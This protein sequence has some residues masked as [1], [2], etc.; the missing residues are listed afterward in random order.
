MARST[1]S[2]RSASGTRQAP[3][4]N[5]VIN[6]G[7]LFEDFES[8]TGWSTPTNGTRDIDTTYVKTGSGSLKFGVNA[9]TANEYI[10]KTISADMSDARNISFWMYIPS[11]HFASSWIIMYF[12]SVSNFSKYFS[13]SLTSKLHEGWNKIVIA[14]SEWLNSGGESWSNTMIR[15]RWRVYADGTNEQLIYFDSIYKQVYS[16]PKVLITFDDGWESQYTKAYAYMQPLGLKGTIYTIGSKIGTAGY[17]TTANLDTLYAAGWDIA[18]HGSV[19]L[20]TLNTQ[21][22]QEAEISSEEAY[23][24]KYQRSKKHY[25]YPGGAYNENARAALSSLEYLTARTIIDRQQANNL[26]EKYLLTRYGIYHTT[27]VATAIGYIDRAIAQGTAILLNF[28]L[29]V[30]ADADVSTK[31]LTADFN[32][33]IDYIKTKVDGNQLD[34][35]TISEWYNGLTNPRKTAISRTVV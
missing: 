11:L 7:I 4:Q 2:N 24:T 1:I 15:M 31:V 5:Y 25:A 3:P 32:S 6:S 26:D 34:V 14:K 18:N 8:L 35:V 28:H 19:L 30:D 33:I 20:T 17:M 22:E 13:I 23:L 21:A 16:R 12:T 10:E 29:I 9:G 27:S